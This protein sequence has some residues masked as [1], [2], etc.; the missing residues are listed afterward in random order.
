M[1]SYFWLQMFPHKFNQIR[2]WTVLWVLLRAPACETNRGQLIPYVS[3]NIPLL[4][5]ADLGTLGVGE[6]RTIDG[7]VNGIILYREADLV[8]HAYDRTCTQYPDHSTGVEESETFEGIYTCP[9]CGSTYI[10]VNGATPDGN[11]GP[12]KYSL[13]EYP[14]SIQGDVLLIRN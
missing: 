14:T 1:F 13:V 9:D 2:S 7:G 11:S 8:F 10:I 12:A 4:L 3:V 6:C 5:Y